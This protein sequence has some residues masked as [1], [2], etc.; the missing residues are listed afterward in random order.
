MKAIILNSGIGKRMGELTQNKPKCLI[1]LINSET[2]LQR[3]LR[4]LQE[5]GITNIIITTGP[6]GDQILNHIEEN[7]FCLN[8][9]YVHNPLYDKT[10]YI[11][12]MNLIRR[13]L[14]DEDIILLHG[15]LVFED[16]VLEKILNSKNLNSVLVNKETSLPRKDFK[17][18]IEE[19]KVKEISIDIFDS[20]CYLLMPLYKFN[21]KDFLLWL[22]KIYIFINRNKCNVYAEEALNEILDEIILGCT[23]YNNELCRE[24]DIPGDLIKANELLKNIY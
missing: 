23:Y 24:I 12:S 21:R 6:Y 1:E 2:I 8:I 7:F 4:I 20:N 16:R 17:G 22:D 5:H 11:Y 9:E 19:G 10:N 3:Q 18:R 14:I 15:D 13:D